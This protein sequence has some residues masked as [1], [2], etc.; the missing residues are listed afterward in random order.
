LWPGAA[1]LAGNQSGVTGGIAASIGFCALPY[2]GNVF[3]AIGLARIF[4]GVAADLAHIVLA[5]A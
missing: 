4:I 3:S 1:L 5:Y 2:A